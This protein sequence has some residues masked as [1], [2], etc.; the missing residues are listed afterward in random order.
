MRLLVFNCHEAWIHQLVAVE[1]ELDIVV[2]LSG[3][4]CA[5]WDARMR[6]FPPCGR[7]VTLQQ[8]GDEG[9]R[10]D[11]LVAHN[12]TD[13]MEA[14][15]IL[16]PRLLVLHST[17]EWRHAKQA[18][19]TSLDELRAVA[20]RYLDLVGGHAVAISPLKAKSWKFPRDI[21]PNSVDVEAYPAWQ[22]GHAA[23]IRVVNEISAKR[24]ALR[25]DFHEAA[26]EGLP[27]TILGHNPDMPGVSA[28]KDWEDLKANLSQHRFFVHTADP[29]YEDG[30][31]MAMLEAMAAGLPVLGNCHP[32]SPIETGVSGFLSDC[33]AELRRHA[34]ALMTDKALAAR[35]GAAAR[36]VAAKKFS[37]ARFN[38]CLMK[39]IK[40][41]KRQ[42][43]RQSQRGAA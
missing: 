22:G 10:Y 3:R 19:T 14:R 43:H 35:L 17:L 37:P 15:A 13:M 32:S 41:A 39:A 29:R 42:W 24:Q 23:G 33:P 7:L 30:Y 1:A 34:E 40:R 9:R 36:E 16:G 8:A 21:L 5:D 12:L 27:V 26:F 20:K 25:W 28:A 38:R 4:Y 11:C 2:G 31:N 18:S 6:P